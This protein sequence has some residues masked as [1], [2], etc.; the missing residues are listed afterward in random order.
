[1]LL[2]FVMAGPDQAIQ[3]GVAIPDARV[4]SGHD[5]WDDTNVPLC[6]CASVVQFLP[7]QVHA[8]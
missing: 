3:G 7:H 5:A 4:K 1:M 6:L 2:S 8:E